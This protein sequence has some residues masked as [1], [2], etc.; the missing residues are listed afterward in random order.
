MWSSQILLDL[1]TFAKYCSWKYRSSTW[2]YNQ[3]S[4]LKLQ[5]RNMEHGQRPY[6]NDLD[7]WPRPI[8]YKKC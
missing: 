8:S 6:I 3:E 2:T 7:S 5:T 1:V 4:G